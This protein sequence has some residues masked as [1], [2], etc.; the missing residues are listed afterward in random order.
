MQ[1]RNAAKRGKNL[2]V[3]VNNDPNTLRPLKQ[4]ITGKGIAR[5]EV[6]SHLK[7]QLYNYR[8]RHN[9]T[10]RVLTQKELA[11]L[12]NQIKQFTD[13]QETPIT[14]DPDQSYTLTEKGNDHYNGKGC[15]YYS[16]MHPDQITIT[17][18]LEQLIGKRVK[19]ETYPLAGEITGI[20]NETITILFDGF[21]NNK[22]IPLSETDGLL[23]QK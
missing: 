2:L 7:S 17:D 18:H 20:T 4:Y 19:H 13:L 15:D 11:Y 1:E 16:T 9:H 23:V 3:L 14:T 21:S 10:R 5:E 12:D 6:L 22:V 8:H